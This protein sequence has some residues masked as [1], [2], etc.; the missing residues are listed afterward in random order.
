MAHR[1]AHEHALSL[2]R[3]VEVV[4]EPPGPDQQRFI[5]AAQGAMVATEACREECPLCRLSGVSFVG[6]V[7]RR[8]GCMRRNRGSA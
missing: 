4:G 6:G 1:R 8:E 5:L 3:H 7:V 2:A